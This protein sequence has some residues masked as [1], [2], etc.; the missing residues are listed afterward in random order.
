MKKIAIVT[1]KMVMGG[2]EKSLLTLLQEFIRYDCQVDLYLAELGGELYRDI[3]PQVNIIC[4]F[5]NGKSA[6]SLL[7]LAAN[8]GSL[9]SVFE[10]FYKIFQNRKENNSSIMWERICSM[11]PI[12][13]VEYDIAIA[14][15]APCSFS[16][17]Y[18]K[19]LN[20]KKHYAW[21]HN[22][23]DHIQEKIS[24]FRGFFDSFDC[25]FCVAKRTRDIFNAIFFEVANQS[26]VFYNIV[27][28]KEI[29]RLSL[30][31]SNIN[32]K[33]LLDNALRIVT[34]GRVCAQK[35][36]DLI[37][38][39]LCRLK[40]DGFTVH[41]YLVGDGD[42]ATEI[43]EK[44]EYFGVSEELI[45][46]GNTLNPYPYFSGC[47]LYVQ[48][49]RH[50][51]FG[52]TIA[53]AK[54]FGKPII[55]TDFAGS[56]EQIIN[57]KDGIIVPFDVESIVNAVQTLLRDESKRVAMGNAAFE[58]RYRCKSDILRILEEEKYIK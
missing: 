45:L 43:K 50:E 37:P 1:N 18:T 14:Y 34:V 26:E 33:F 8:K 20:S 51:G 44:A 12:P 22:E 11:L 19:Q 58:S 48:P 23:V 24:N 29:Y 49:S 21:I 6:I 5:P 55:L 40:E 9:K 16:V 53:E 27:D 47:D 2:I 38:E 15:S 54:H 52:I 42:I 31:T 41:W 39:I 17:V 56:D 35:G 13:N 7:K 28:E 36:Q 57:G 32:K 10:A 46:C 3:P 30:D 4:I 25:I